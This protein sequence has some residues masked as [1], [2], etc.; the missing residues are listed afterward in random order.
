V[1]VGMPMVEVVSPDGRKE[2]WAAAVAHDDAVEAVR[3]AI[4]ADYA[5]KATSRRLPLGPRME[6]FR[7]GEVRRVEP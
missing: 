2:L 5:A 6:G 4:P 1:Y 7:Y 3:K